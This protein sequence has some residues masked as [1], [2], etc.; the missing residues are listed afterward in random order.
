MTTLDDAI[1]WFEQTYGD[2][3]QWEAVARVLRSVASASADA[4]E[5]FREFQ[6]Q[7]YGRVVEKRD[8]DN[9]A[10]DAYL[11]GHAAA[12]AAKQAEVDGLRAELADARAHTETVKRVTNRVIQAHKA[13]LSAMCDEVVRCWHEM[14][15]GRKNFE[16][17]FLLD[18]RPALV[19]E[20]LARRK[21]QINAVE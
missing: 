20:I 8:V 2:T 9:Y 7:R 5:G 13:D 3:E 21:E 16:I 19:T 6:L 4:E 10:R 17:S 15:R 12:T 11:A 14:E 1:K 18:N